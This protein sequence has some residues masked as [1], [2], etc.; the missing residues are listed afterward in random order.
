M[1]WRD[2]LFL[3]PCDYNRYICYIFTHK[4]N[5]METTATLFIVIILGLLILQIVMIV[6]FFQ[7]ASDV[8]KIRQG[9]DGESAVNDIKKYIA[10][11]RFIGNEEKVRET[12]IR[13]RIK[14]E[15]KLNYAQR[16]GVPTG[17][18]QSKIHYVDSQLK[19]IGINPDELLRQ[20]NTK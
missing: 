4:F 18:I 10:T 9:M 12:L 6:K 7:I 3:L 11:E 16:A 19:E 15:D 13:A 17:H 14:W 8:Q 5:A 20:V 2:Y 1:Y